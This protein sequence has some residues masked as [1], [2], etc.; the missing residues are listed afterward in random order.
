MTKSTALRKKKETVIGDTLVSS[1]GQILEQI[2]STPVVE[3]C[4]STM[5]TMASQN[6]KFKNSFLT[7]SLSL[8]GSKRNTVMKLVVDHLLKE[9]LQNNHRK[10]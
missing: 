9:P 8:A 3:E 5:V 7:S 1:F 4:L 6:K 2:Y 10:M